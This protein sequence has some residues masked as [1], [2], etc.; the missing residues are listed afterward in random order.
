MAIKGKGKGEVIITPSPTDV[1]PEDGEI[2][3]IG[4]EASEQAFEKHFAK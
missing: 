2:I 1:F 3:L 4:D